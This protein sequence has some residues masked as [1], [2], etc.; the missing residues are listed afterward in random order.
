M[1]GFSIDKVRAD[2][3]ILQQKIG[4][5]RLVYFDNAATTQKPKVVIEALNSYYRYENANVHRGIHYLSEQA[6]FAYENARK[7]VKEYINAPQEKEIIFVRGVTEGINLL[8]N[9]F[10]SILKPK[11]EILITALE[12]HA[13]IVPWQMIASKTGAKLKVIPIDKGGE[14][15]WQ[16]IEKSFSEHTKLLSCVH[17]SNAIGTVV[18]IERLGKI[19][20]KFRVP[21][22]VDGAQSAAHLPIDVQNIGCDFY[23]FSAHKVLGPTGIGVLWGKED[24]LEKLP[25]YQG[26]G[27]MIER[28]SFESTTYK[29]IPA[30]FEAGTP[31][32]AG[33]IGL[34]EALLYLNS[35]DT[36]GMMKHEAGLLE[37]ATEQ[38]MEI[39]DLKI[40]GE[41]SEKS[42]ILN[43][44]VKSIHPY[45][46]STFLDSQGIAVRTGLHCAEPLMDFLGS[47][48]TTRASLAFYNTFEEID[49]LKDALIKAVALFK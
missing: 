47:G 30:K 39:P 12:H 1:G 27:D 14:I 10:G 48:A 22:I 28:V 18:A 33:G 21:M 4:G 38:L 34:S 23:L 35:L 5:K 15:V 3:P 17:I 42:C 26:G 45:D 11:D 2:F 37:Y 31:H 43:F 16:D 7:V 20:K 36:E 25:P 13:N 19:A 29:D 49:C 9:G 32:I 46:I 40:W 6:T 44:S 41:A 24:W 8:A